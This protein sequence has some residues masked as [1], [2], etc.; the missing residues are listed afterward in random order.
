MNRSRHEVPG[1]VE[2]IG[3]GVYTALPDDLVNVVQGRQAVVVGRSDT[4]ASVALKLSDCGCHVTVVTCETARGARIP[5]KVRRRPNVQ[6]RYRTELAWAV[7]IDHLEAVV[8]RNLTSGRVEACNADALLVLA[9]G[10]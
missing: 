1:V 9:D 10:R 2:L 8:L 7:G 5:G 4:A 6:V 3:H